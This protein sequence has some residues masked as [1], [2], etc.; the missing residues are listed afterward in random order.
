M[1]CDQRGLVHA[2]SLQSCPILCNPVYCIPPGSSLSMGFS[3]QDYWGG[4]PCPLP[5]DLPDPGI[6]PSPLMSPELAH[7]FLPLVPLGKPGALLSFSQAS[8]SDLCFPR[9]FI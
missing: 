2:K 3:R 5:E 8:D 9:G 4:F 1:F 6:K 7:V